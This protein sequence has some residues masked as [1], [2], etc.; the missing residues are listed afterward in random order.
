MK[1]GNAGEGVSALV[2][3]GSGIKK[4]NAQI[5]GRISNGGL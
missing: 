3:D 4:G 5:N 2:N 1:N